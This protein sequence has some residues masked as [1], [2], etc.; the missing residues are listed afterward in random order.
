MKPI[1]ITMKFFGSYKDVTI[2]FSKMNSGIFLI[3][4]DTGAGKTT[5]FDAITYAL[6]GKSSGNKRDGEMMISQFAAPNE[7]TEVIFCFKYGKNKYIVKRSPEQKRYK[8]KIENNKNKIYKELKSSKKSTLQLIMPDGSL[9]NGTIPEINQKIQEIVGIDASQFVQ[10]AM[11]AQGDFLRLLHASSNDRQEIFAK[12][13]DT[14]LYDMMQQELK[15]EFKNLNTMLENNEIEIKRLLSAIV[16]SKESSLSETWRENGRFSDDKNSEIL[17]LIQCI[18]NE[19]N[20]LINRNEEELVKCKQ[21]EEWIQKSLNEARQVNED[22]DNLEQLEKD[23]ESLQLKEKDIVCIK[24]QYLNAEQAMKVSESYNLYL[25]REKDLDKKMREVNE[26]S[27][28]V[29]E[30]NNRREILFYKKLEIDEKYKQEFEIKINEISLLESKMK[31]FD[32]IQEE[33]TQYQSE[34]NKLKQKQNEQLDYKIKEDSTKSKV[35]ALMEDVEKLTETAIKSDAIERELEQFNRDKKDL[36]ELYSLLV[37][38]ENFIKELEEQK[39]QYDKIQNKRE[40]LENQYNQLYKE[41]INKQAHI[42]RK[43]L[44]EGK[45]CPVCGS[46]EHYVTDFEEVEVI[47]EQ[48]VEKI[49][50]QLDK[51]V[52][53]ENIKREQLTSLQLQEKENNK[54]INKY[55]D[56]FKLY[57]NIETLKDVQTCIETIKTAI[58]KLKQQKLQSLEATKLLETTKMK[59]EAD[60][61]QLEQI[62]NNK[63]QIDIDIASIK[64]L[65]SQI[66]K[67]LDIKVKKLPFATKK[68]AQD[69]LLEMKQYK[70]D[71]ERNKKENDAEYQ[72]TGERMEALNAAYQLIVKERDELIE[73]EETAQRIFLD[74]LAKNKFLREEEFLKARMSDDEIKQLKDEITEYEQSVQHTDF[75]IKL[76]LE[77]TKGKERIDITKYNEEKKKIED[78]TKRLQDEGKKIYADRKINQQSYD[79]IKQQYKKRE[80][81]K[82]QYVILKNL[83]D[84]ANGKLSRKK[85]DFQTYIQRR[86]FK[87]VIAAANTR[88]IKMT[89]NQ[90]CLKCRDIK[91]LRAKGNTDVGLDLDVYNIISDQIRDVKTLSGGESFMASLCMALGLSDIIQNKAGKIQIQTMFIDEGF[92]TLSEEVRNQALEILNELSGDNILIGIISHVKELR[93]QI[94]AKLIVTK[95]EDGSKAEWKM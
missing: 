40:D 66:K 12:I 95:T 3:T 20:Y 34:L 26:Y 52:K 80:E 21:K 77:K 65:T 43:M 41:F 59:L 92:G 89:N 72:K 69:N 63:K 5:I 57:K 31:E 8:E 33:Q 64:A 25:D 71:L 18:I 6:Y 50:Q 45:P 10:I 13:F 2:D 42:I 55:K 32:E 27:V 4:G 14:G 86:Y 23:R 85:I 49:K 17:A 11:L 93:E 39:K 94:D 73:R 56:K 68:E 83:H 53:E 58:Q 1:Y 24:R 28:K 60:K 16:C 79:D 15:N 91:E 82:K 37:K 36:E 22:F 62:Q 9:F 51:S 48:E 90:F 7:F 46:K 35:A 29:E 67:S 84:T 78:L 30:C 61:E 81:L 19:L 38:K 88:L 47:S 54:Q 44:I 87:K 70:D 75:K 76:F 74:N